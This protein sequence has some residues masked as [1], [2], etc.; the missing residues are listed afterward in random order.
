MNK[1]L[2]TLLSLSL[3]FNIYLIV[4]ENKEIEDESVKEEVNYITVDL[5]KPLI[6]DSSGYFINDYR[7]SEGKVTIDEVEITNLSNVTDI[8]IAQLG[9]GVE[10]TI[11]LFVVSHDEIYY[12][13]QYK[14]D[15]MTLNYE[16]DGRLELTEVVK[17]ID[18]SFYDGGETF[19]VRYDG[20]FYPLSKLI[21]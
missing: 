12:M 11:Y 14:E 3:V 1:I 20:S 15:G 2:I 21:K 4:N 17:I 7:I 13:Y 5:S 9:Q 16:I 6:G 10:G 19:L 18:G 8:H